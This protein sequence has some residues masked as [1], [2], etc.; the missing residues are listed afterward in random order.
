MV[1]G[2][3]LHDHRRHFFA[4]RTRALCRTVLGGLGRGVTFG[5]TLGGWL[6]DQWSWRACFWVNLPVGAIAVT[7]IYLSSRT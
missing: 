1:D 7:A 5:P 6:T 3:A 2:P 4:E